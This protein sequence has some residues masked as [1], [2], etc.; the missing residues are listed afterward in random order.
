V[1]PAAKILG[2][3]AVPSETREV[4]FALG[5]LLVVAGV[6]VLPRKR[7]DPIAKLIGLR[8]RTNRDGDERQDTPD[9]AIP[10]A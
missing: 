6:A 9:Q 8:R 4:E 3:I 10:A 7:F 1:V 5:L 2:D